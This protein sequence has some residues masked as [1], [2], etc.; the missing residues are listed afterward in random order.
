[1][2]KNDKDKLSSLRQQAEGLCQEYNDAIQSGK[3]DYATQ[4]DEALT[5]AINEY[6]SIVRTMC[7]DECKAS[8]DPLR[9]AVT[10]LTYTTIGTKDEKVS[11]DKVPVRSIVEKERPI[12]L[13]KLHKYVGGDGIGANKAWPHIAQKMNFTLT[14]QAAKDLGIDPKAV[15]DSY[16]MSDIA[17]QYDLG[18]NPASNTNLLK[19][20]QTVITAMLGEDAKATSHDVNFLKM[21]YAKKNRKALTVTCANHR[22]FV[23]YIAE[24]CHRIVTGKTYGVEF[25]AKKGA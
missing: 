11:D 5:K 15:N 12:D 4:V 21:V 17:A 14:A 19:T 18:K 20:I 10:M 13:L 1:M 6:T 25:K 23:N 24:I 22:Y 16:S 3:F 9:A 7:F 2:A 8:P